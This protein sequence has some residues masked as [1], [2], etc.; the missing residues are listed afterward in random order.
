MDF[1]I[2]GETLITSSMH[3]DYYMNI[4]RKAL[5]KA[6]VIGD[7]P[8]IHRLKFSFGSNINPSINKKFNLGYQS[9]PLKSQDYIIQDLPLS[10]KGF[11]SHQ[12]QADS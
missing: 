11:K 8:A 6:I 5:S 9:D 1:R 7:A 4:A 3:I 10:K 12:A 2:T